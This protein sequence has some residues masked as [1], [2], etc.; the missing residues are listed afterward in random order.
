M[1]TRQILAKTRQ[2]NWRVPL[3]KLF[4]I[5]PVYDTQ[6]IQERTRQII[7]CWRTV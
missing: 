4:N 2:I 1:L 7:M 6:Q 5:S 3:H